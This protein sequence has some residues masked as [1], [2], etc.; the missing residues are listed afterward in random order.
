MSE[1]VSR[2]GDS[3]VL[4]LG[5]RRE[6]A[7]WVS[8]PVPPPAPTGARGRLLAFRVGHRGGPLLFL[9]F[10]PHMQ[11]HEC[12]L[13]P[14]GNEGLERWARVRELGDDCQDLHESFFFYDCC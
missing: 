7:H 3:E 4:R 5:S 1:G 12:T 13:A 14:P 11:L 8:A 10:A 6:M 2:M 9:H